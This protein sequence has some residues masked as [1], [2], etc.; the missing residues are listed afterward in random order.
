MYK[1]SSNGKRGVFGSFHDK[2]KGKQHAYIC[3]ISKGELIFFVVV[4]V[5]FNVISINLKGTRSA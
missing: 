1:R 3:E 5:A 2:L 4:V